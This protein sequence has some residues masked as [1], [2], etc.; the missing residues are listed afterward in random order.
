MK[1]NF[2]LKHKKMQEWNEQACNTVYTEFFYAY[3]T[4]LE[5]KGLM[6]GIKFSN[7]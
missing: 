5:T 1:Q 7:K 2:N 6:G 4:N 3:W